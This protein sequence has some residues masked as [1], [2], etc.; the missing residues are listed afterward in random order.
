MNFVLYVFYYGY[1]IFN[2]CIRVVINTATC[3]NPNGSRT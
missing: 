2:N 1:N 3:F